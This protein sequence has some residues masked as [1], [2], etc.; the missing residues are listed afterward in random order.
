MKPL[1]INT[2][3]TVKKISMGGDINTLKVVDTAN[4]VRFV[5]IAETDD[6]GN[7]ILPNTDYLAVLEWAAIDGNTIAEAD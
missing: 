7:L 6:S 5:P 3:N 2:I 4:D 1:G